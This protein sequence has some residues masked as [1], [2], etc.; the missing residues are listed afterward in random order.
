MKKRHLKSCH[1][2]EYHIPVW[3]H[4]LLFEKPRL[5]LSY[6]SALNNPHN[7]QVSN[8]NYIMEFL[9]PTCF[10]SFCN[11]SRTFHQCPDLSA[12]PKIFHVFYTVN[13]HTISIQATPC[14]PTEAS[15]MGRRSM[16]AHNDDWQPIKT[17]FWSAALCHLLILCNCSHV[18]SLSINLS[19]SLE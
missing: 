15:N 14:L 16:A 12:L 7:F 18:T 3:I 2:F 6:L 1:S 9:Q 10:L 13:T 4:S 8:N 11:L 19:S 17:A 5:R